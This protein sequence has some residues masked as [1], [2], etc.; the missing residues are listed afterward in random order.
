MISF[1]TECI[2]TE[3]AAP[4]KWSV[5][6]RYENKCLGYFYA[7]DDQVGSVL[8]Y[9][10]DICESEG[11]EA[12][13]NLALVLLYSQQKSFVRV[14]G[15]PFLL[16]F[17]KHNCI[18]IESLY[19]YSL[20]LPVVEITAVILEDEYGRVL[21]GKRPQGYIMPGLWEFP[22]GKRESGETFLDAGIREI[23]EELNIEIIQPERFSSFD[24]CFL[25]NRLKGQ[26]LLARQWE[27]EIKN[28]HHSQLQWVNPC[29]FTNYAM[30]LSNVLCGVWDMVKRHPMQD[31]MPQ[32]S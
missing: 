3:S 11:I 15:C 8:Q 13:L 7:H 18:T 22:G 4:G 6:N 14:M 27:G 10:T 17:A 1:N 23:R 31:K 32:Y 30:P 26:F 5:Y 24:F 29:D 19:L 21:L 28:M 16:P 20:Q 2:T 9:D 25:K 12:I